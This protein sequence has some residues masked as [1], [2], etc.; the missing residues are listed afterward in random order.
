MQLEQGERHLAVA[1]ELWVLLVAPWQVWST[2]ACLSWCLAL[3]QAC[4]SGRSK[5]AEWLPLLKAQHGE[6]MVWEEQ[7]RLCLESN[8]GAAEPRRLRSDELVLSQRGAHGIRA[9][10]S[11]GKQCVCPGD[12]VPVAPQLA[13]SSL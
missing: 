9:L 5:D 2:R 12:G 8:A 3:A 11:I 4:P 13:C 1:G 10:Q 6:D 7:H